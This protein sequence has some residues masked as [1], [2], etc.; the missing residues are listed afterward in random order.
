MKLLDTF[1][2]SSQSPITVQGKTKLDVHFDVFELPKTTCV[3]VKQ[4]EQLE[5]SFHPTRPPPQIIRKEIGNKV[6]R[7]AKI[8][9]HH[10]KIKL[11]N[12]KTFTM[13]ILQCDCPGAY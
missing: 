10:C 3:S 12:Y 13:G 1:T 5:C 8:C 9:R 6:H 4:K 11:H 7:S 2:T